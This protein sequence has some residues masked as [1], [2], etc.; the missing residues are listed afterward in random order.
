MQY[1]YWFFIY[2]HPVY[3]LTK[4]AWSDDLLNLEVG[5]WKVFAIFG[6]AVWFAF[7]RYFAEEPGNRHGYTYLWWILFSVFHIYGFFFYLIYDYFA[8]GYKTSKQNSRRI[9]FADMPKASG[10]GKPPGWDSPSRLD[11]RNKFLKKK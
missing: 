10:L 8:T 4:F 1:I 2:I 7:T 6:T 9:R 3:W 11:R 5:P